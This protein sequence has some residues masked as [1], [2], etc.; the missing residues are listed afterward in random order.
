MKIRFLRI[1]LIVVFLFSISCSLMLSALSNSRDGIYLIPKGYT[2]EVIIIFDQPDGVAPEVE[3]GLFVYKIPVDG[4]LK[5]K[6]HRYKGIVSQSYFYVDREGQR[7]QLKYLRITGSDDING[8][9]K[10]KFDGQITQD[11]YENGVFV[12]SHEQTASK[13]SNF[14]VGA[15]KDSNRL[16][17]KMEDRISN[18]L[19]EGLQ[20]N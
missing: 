14:T 18:I 9:P 7:E 12:M 20:G 3:D 11:E 1:V 5:V 17:D 2:G 4:L 15:P 8:R 6:A 13:I 10:D 16:Y 19:R